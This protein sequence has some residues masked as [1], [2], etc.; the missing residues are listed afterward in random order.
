MEDFS[1]TDTS[2]YCI[3]KYISNSS[4]QNVEEYVRKQISGSVGKEDIK[5]VLKYSKNH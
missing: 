5:K 3:S 2:G 4:R 1:R